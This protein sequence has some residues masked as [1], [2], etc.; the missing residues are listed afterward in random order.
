MST[1]IVNHSQEITVSLSSIPLLSLL[2]LY[3]CELHCIRRSVLSPIGAHCLYF[4]RIWLALFHVIQTCREWALGTSHTPRHFHANVRH[5][6]RLRIF[7]AT[8]N[9]NKYIKLHCILSCIYILLHR[10][11]C[12][13]CCHAVLYI[14]SMQHTLSHAIIVYPL[15]FGMTFEM[16]D[17][18]ENSAQTFRFTYPHTHAHNHNTSSIQSTRPAEQLSTRCLSI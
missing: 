2:I 6:K 17:E 9:A 1:S 16:A 7:C 12:L 14:F 18:I 11:C 10:T 8:S 3:I 13:C 4:I 15:E 5:T